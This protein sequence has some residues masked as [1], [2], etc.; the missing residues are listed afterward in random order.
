MTQLVEAPTV[1]FGSGHD[2]RVVRW[3]LLKLLPLPL[4]I[5]SP[6]VSVS[7]KK[8]GGGEGREGRLDKIISEV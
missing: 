2:V 1:D 3:N 4:P 7:N 8:R 6:S 5:P